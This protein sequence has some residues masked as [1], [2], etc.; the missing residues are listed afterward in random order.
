MANRQKT[1]NTI[2]GTSGTGSGETRATRGVAAD[3]GVRRG[4]AGRARKG[5][6]VSA[7]PS[8][9]QRGNASKVLD[10]LQH[11][12]WLAPNVD[13]GQA[14]HVIGLVIGGD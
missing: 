10:T 6:T 12:G 8:N 3:T 11:M 14:E 5:A 4:F 9:L 13:R 7:T 2:G 1:G